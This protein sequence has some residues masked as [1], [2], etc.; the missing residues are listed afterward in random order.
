MD[1]YTK[2]DV[3]LGYRRDFV[4]K[5]AFLKAFKAELKLY[6]LF[7]TSYLATPMA[8]D[9]RT[10]A[11]TSSEHR[12]AFPLPWVLNSDPFY[13]LLTTWSRGPACPRLSCFGY[14][15]FSQRFNP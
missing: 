4:D 11:T 14:H 12:E 15:P 8:M 6:N 7:D 10:P 1:A 2:I 13:Q 5:Q 9:M 3:N